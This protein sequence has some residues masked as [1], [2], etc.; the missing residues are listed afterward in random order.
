MRSRPGPKI[1]IEGVP[2]E[3]LLAAVDAAYQEMGRHARPEDVD[4]YLKMERPE[5]FGP[6]ANTRGVQARHSLYGR[7]RPGRS[8]PAGR[9]P[10]ARIG[11]VAVVALGEE[12]TVKHSNVIA[13]VKPADMSPTWWQPIVEQIPYVVDLRVRLGRDCGTIIAVVRPQSEHR[14]VPPSGSIQASL[15][16]ATVLD[17]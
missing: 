5:V 10:T 7:L 11:A 6:L 3:D 4:L 1:H 16:D 8:R 2:E 9:F 17:G 12:D 13:R 14:T 15:A